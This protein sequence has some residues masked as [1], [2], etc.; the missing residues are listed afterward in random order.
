[1]FDWSHGYNV[2][3]G[4][5]YGYYRE[6]APNW[7]DFVAAIKG[8]L[9]PARGPHGSF[10]YLELGCGQGLGLCLLAAAHPAGDFVG[11]DFNPEHIGHA[12]RLAEAAGLANVR[13]E[14]GDF[15]ELA[16][17]W[18][19]RMG[20]FDYVT[21]HG[22]YS[23]LPP[24]VRAGLVKCI[25][26]ATHPGSLVYVSYNAL[27]GWLSTVP[28][29]HIA[30]QLQLATGQAGPS[31][32]QAT[33]KLFESIEAANSPL[34]RILPG[35]KTR[36]DAIKAQNPNYLVQ[37][38]LHDHW[39]PLW[40]SQVAGEL[41]AI[42]L[43]FVGSAHLPEALM[44]ALLPAAMRDLVLAQE[45]P[46]LRQDVMDCLINQGFRRDV[47]CRGPLQSFANGASAPIMQVSLVLTT[48]PAG[49]VKVA[50]TVGEAKVAPN[51]VGP[52]VEELGKGPR[53]IAQLTGLPQLRS[54]ANVAIAIQAIILLVHAGVVMLAPTETVPATSA[55]GLNRVIAKAV[56]NGA[57]Y[58][59]VAAPVLGTAIQT[60]DVDLLLLDA[61]L[62]QAGLDAAGLGEALVAGLAK[63]GRGL[64]SSDGLLTGDA[65]NQR[66][67]DLSQTFLTTKL[68][69]WS[70]WGVVDG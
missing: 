55:Q 40:F 58:Q 11:V 30:R 9:P 68:P 70:S 23:W 10:R 4:Y 38:Y 34:F 54:E 2:S 50:T 65:L 66:A 26:A 32:L 63:L 20:S 25:D 67:A 15:L 22:I 69:R 33:A 61:W 48:A 43:G 3:T 14:E 56:A 21:Q 35:L 36:L 7:L 13:F 1:M 19:R 28:F 18:P 44:P 47:F 53:T 52:V 24:A 5:T 51:I 17:D 27:P 12:R 39:H 64:N 31:A 45:N 16:Q 8:L 6:L 57:P 42:K 29:Q 59:Y 62:S 41:G 60:N 37:E 49:E 46:T